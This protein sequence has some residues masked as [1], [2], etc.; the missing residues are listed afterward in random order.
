[1]DYRNGP[2]EN[3]MLNAG[4]RLP[5]HAIGEGS[6]MIAHVHGQGESNP[7]PTHPFW[8]A[9]APDISVPA[10]YLVPVTKLRQLLSRRENGAGVGDRIM[11]IHRAEAGGVLQS[12]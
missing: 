9:L 7:T 1:M 5:S 6:S 2:I 4:L 3:E 12:S 11:E 8:H 10:Y